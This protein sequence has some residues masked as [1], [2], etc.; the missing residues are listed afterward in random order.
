VSQPSRKDE[1]LPKLEES[2]QSP[3]NGEEQDDDGYSDVGSIAMYEDG[4][5]TALQNELLQDLFEHDPAAIDMPT[6]P[7]LLQEFAIR[8]GHQGESSDSRNMMYF[9]HKLSRY[10]IML[11]IC[12]CC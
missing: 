5:A 6:L 8:I 9:A 3:G 7:L 2:Y 12:I 1:T 4:Y 11:T 10:V